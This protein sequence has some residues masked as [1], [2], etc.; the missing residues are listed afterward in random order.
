MESATRR[1]RT[2]VRCV[3]AGGGG[4]G[5]RTDVVSADE[6][7]DAERVVRG[8]LQRLVAARR[9][10]SRDDD[11]RVHAVRGEDD[12]HGVIVAGVAV[13]PQV[14]RHGAR[15]FERPLRSGHLGARGGQVLSGF[16]GPARARFRRPTSS[17]PRTE[18]GE[19]TRALVSTSTHAAKVRRPRACPLSSSR[20]SPLAPSTPPSRARSSAEIPRRR[21]ADRRTA[22]PSN[23]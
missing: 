5:A 3:L 13:E 10:D 7:E 23:S 15:R 20:R 19:R 12:G 1:A 16:G 4:C 11:V 2:M 21:E 22:A 6:V 8:L 14:R 9:A 18:T 17:H